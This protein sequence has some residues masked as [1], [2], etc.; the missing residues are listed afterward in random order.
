MKLSESALKEK[1]AK[2]KRLI[3]NYRALTKEVLQA[4][5]DRIHTQ[6]ILEKSELLLRTNPEFNAI[7][8]LRKEIF[9]SDS[10]RVVETQIK[11]L[12]LELV[13]VMELIM[14]YPKCYWI[15]NHRRWCLEQ[16][17][18]YDKANWKY[19][20]KLV[21]KLLDMDSRNF[22]GWHYR[23]YVVG[24]MEK[25]APSSTAILQLNIEELDFT[26]QKINRST[27]N[28]SAW[29]NRTKLI[30]KIYQLV[31]DSEVSGN[32][33]IVAR[34]QSLSK[35]L[36]FELNLVKTGMYMS[37]DDTS[38]WLYMQWLITD[39]LFVKHLESEGPGAR[40]ALLSG[41]YRDVNE[42]NELEKDESAEKKDNLW[43]LKMLITLATE[44]NKEEPSKLLREDA[45]SKL[46]FLTEL[47]PMRKERYLEYLS[48]KAVEL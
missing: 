46:K 1:F 37:A 27:A 32:T 3:H 20:L 4:K 9:R 24:R 22:H 33:E 19:E 45:N 15:W 17:D 42:L 14:R 8:N 31:K 48:G 30:P 7:W 2:D 5:A 11:S 44:L 41:L 28:F 39:D 29:H 23:R 34:F 13:I 12:S 6:E 18:T 25:K 43:C 36:E 21:Q 26:T 38:V 16:L 10:Y 47:D 35:V 40:K